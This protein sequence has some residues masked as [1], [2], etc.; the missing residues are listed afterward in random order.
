MPERFKCF[1]CQVVFIF[2]LWK[3]KLSR[4]ML[5][6]DGNNKYHDSIANIC[7]NKTNIIFLL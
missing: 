5:N 7:Q 4:P 2:F 1:V 6:E 3:Q